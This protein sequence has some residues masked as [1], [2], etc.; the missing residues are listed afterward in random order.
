M[1]LSSADYY[2]RFG[3]V[4]AST[5]GITGP[6][7]DVDEFKAKGLSTEPT[8]AGPLRYAEPFGIAE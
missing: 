3:F 5:L 4:R 8:L 1:V 2:R 7:G 6:F